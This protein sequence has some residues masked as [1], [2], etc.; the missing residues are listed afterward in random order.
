[1]I[2]ANP[3]LDSASLKLTH[4]YNYSQEIPGLRLRLWMPSATVLSAESPW[5]AVA[6]SGNLY[7]Q[8]HP[9]PVLLILSDAEDWRAARQFYGDRLDLPRLHIL[10]GAD[11]RHWGHGALNQPAVR[12]ALG[13]AVAASLGRSGRLTEP[14]QISPIGLDPEDLPPPALVKQG[15]LILGCDYPA[16]GLAVQQRLLASGLPCQCELSAWPKQKWQE[17]LAKASVAI[18]LNPQDGYPGL[19]LRTLTAMALGTAVVVTKNLI[20][21][22]Y[23]RPGRNSVITMADAKELTEAATKLLKDDEQRKVLV[24]GGK[25]TLL[26]HR[27]ALERNQYIELIKNFNEHWTIAKSAHKQE[28]GELQ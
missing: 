25:S 28:P 23:C 10:Q 19:G 5:Q 27:T 22:F 12:L 11:A 3:G 2:V 6:H 7:S 8:P 18:I 13:E 4:I 1:M 17:A 16:L 15:C 24:Q 26:R 14:L 21:D 9:A 20:P